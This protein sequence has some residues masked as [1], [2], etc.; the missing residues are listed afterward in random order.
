M[1]LIL[2]IETSGKAC[3]VALSQYTDCKIFKSIEEDDFKHAEGLHLL[4]EAVVKEAGLTLK[5]LQAVAVSK[6]P[7]SYTGLRVGVSAAKGLC[8]ALDIPLLGI[9]TLQIIASQAKQKTSGS[10]EKY[11]AMI[12]ARREEVYL[13]EFDTDLNPLSEA[14][15]VVLPDYNVQY[16]NTVFCGDGS[17]KAKNYFQGENLLFVPEAK[18]MANFMCTYAAKA[19][20]EKR[21]EDTAYF[22]PF[23]LKEFYTGSK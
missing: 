9:D 3:S 8:Y 17:L 12:D 21:F 23:Y 4:A 14:R 7:G 13:R 2:N 20:D 10:F 15:A 6:G 19:F 16:N 18:A 5:D 11:V 1:A 22:E